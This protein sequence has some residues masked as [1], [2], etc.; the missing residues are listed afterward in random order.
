MLSMQA[1]LESDVRKL[2]QQIETLHSQIDDLNARST[3]EK[4]SIFHLE[5]KCSELGVKNDVGVC[6]W[7]EEF[8][9]TAYAA[10]AESKQKEEQL[11]AQIEALS[12]EKVQVLI[13]LPSSN[14]VA[15]QCTCPH[16]KGF[17]LLLPG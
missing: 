1:Q 12:L 4:V 17:F 14:P 7:Q 15:I 6:G 5:P 2:T 9:S 16:H 3:T 8:R 11:T 10:Q 13:D